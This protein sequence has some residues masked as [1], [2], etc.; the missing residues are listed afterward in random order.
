VRGTIFDVSHE[1]DDSTIVTVEEGLVSVRHLLKPGKEVLV[2][3]NESIRVLPNQPLAMRQIDKG[4][5]FRKVMEAL[6]EAGYEVARRPTSGGGTGPSPAPTS[7]PNADQGKED[8]GGT[9]TGPAAPPPPPPGN[10]Q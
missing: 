2:G 4:S 3:P 10:G 1:S 9:S 6:R 8:K 5:I 7:G